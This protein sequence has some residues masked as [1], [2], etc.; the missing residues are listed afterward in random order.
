MALTFRG[1]VDVED[2]KNARKSPIEIFPPPKFVYIPMSQHIGAH[3]A[4]FVKAGDT[5]DKGQMIAGNNTAALSCPIHSSVSGKVVSIEKRTLSTGALTEFIVIEND[6][7]DRFHV[8]VKPFG[9]KINDTTPE[10]VIEIIKNAGIVGMGGA[11]FPTHAKI[12]SALNKVTT[13]IVN[14]AECEPYITANHRL[15]LERPEM[16]INGVKIL[17]KTLGLKLGYIAVEDNKLNAADS[18]TAAAAKSKMIEIKILKTKYPQGDERQLIYALTGK[19]LPSGKFPTD[20]GYVVFNPETC[21]AIC[22]AFVSGMPMIERIVTVDG[23]CVMNPKNLVVPIGVP[24]TEVIE[25]CGLKKQPK[26]IIKNGPMMGLAVFDYKNPVTK[27]TAALLAFSEDRPDKGTS[28]CIRCGKCVSG[29][30]MRLYPSYL[31]LF[32]QNEDLDKCEK[33]GV[34]SCV[35]CGCCTYICPAKVPIVQHIRKAKGRISEK[36]RREEAKASAMLSDAPATP[37]AYGGRSAAARPKLSDK[38]E[39]EKETETSAESDKE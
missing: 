12:K 26:K 2:R 23:D 20:C 27:G 35:E 33:Y 3:A 28:E 34:F 9:K 29:C 32:S 39:K 24:V 25:Y 14:C 7:Q 36:H 16:I 4:P 38:D 11:M 6:F 1:G 31:A 19:E 21:A 15:M 37:T 10:E 30:Q 5:V 13:L 8:S 17:L 22:A 18:L